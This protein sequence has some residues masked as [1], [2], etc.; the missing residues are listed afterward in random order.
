MLYVAVAIVCSVAAA[1][2][3]RRGDPQAQPSLSARALSF[4][5]AAGIAAV[6]AAATGDFRAFGWP[7]LLLG[8]ASGA[9]FATAHYLSWRAVGTD[10]LAVSPALLTGAMI[11]PGVIGLLL[12]GESSNVYTLGG[13][14]AAAVGLVLL[15][16]GAPRVRAEGHAG[17]RAAWTVVLFV[18]FALQ[19]FALQF[20]VAVFLGKGRALYLLFTCAAAALALGALALSRGERL[21]RR[22]FLSGGAI[23]ALRLL[24]L[25]FMLLAMDV[26][27]TSMVF[28]LMAVG[29]VAL[30]LLLERI[31]FARLLRSWSYVGLVVAIAAVGLLVAFSR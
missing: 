12:F 31:L 21:E 1:L 2:L 17:A 10:H 4:L 25:M 15:G 27:P 9:V 6:W 30:V 28:A 7:L 11:V 19:F 16:V 29:H 26:L 5:V 18:F 22:E 20:F 13:L 14:A 8:L 23:G 3:G 24:V